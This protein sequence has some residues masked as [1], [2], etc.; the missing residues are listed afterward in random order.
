MLTVVSF[1]D[2]NLTEFSRFY[3][4]NNPA[5]RSAACKKFK[6]SQLGKLLDRQ[7]EMHLS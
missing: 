5:S 3:I 4:K 2:G 1:P 6:Q 7:A